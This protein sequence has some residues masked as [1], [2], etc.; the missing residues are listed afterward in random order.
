MPAVSACPAMRRASAHPAIPAKKCAW[1][2][3][4]RS[5]G[6]TFSTLL[7]STNP[8]GIAPSRI[9]SSSQSAAPAWISL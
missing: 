2:V 1:V 4:V 5:D 9:N 8:A 6:V 3:P 7:R